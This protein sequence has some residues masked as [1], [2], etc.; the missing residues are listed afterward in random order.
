MRYNQI[1]IA[2]LISSSDEFNVAVSQ[3]K[4]KWGE[5]RRSLRSSKELDNLLA[6]REQLVQRKMSP[7]TIDKRI[8]AERARI[9]RS[10]MDRPNKP[11]RAAT[12]EI[13]AS[14]KSSAGQ[15]AQIIYD[16]KG[17]AVGYKAPPATY[18]GQPKMP[19]SGNQKGY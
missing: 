13:S 1:N 3:P 19:V 17:K 15:S 10:E 11:A 7:E 8:A 14:R 2:R 9:V 5:P 6:M 18:F 16:D 12:M 4:E